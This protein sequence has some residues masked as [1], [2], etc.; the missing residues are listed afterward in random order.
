MPK[1]TKIIMGM[2]ITVEIIDKVASSVFV[3]VFDYFSAIDKRYSTYKKSSE[4]SQING[5]L[6]QLKWSTEMKT[7]FDLCEQT[8]QQTNGYFDIYH[9]DRL[10]PSG[11]VK[12]WSIQNAA[13]L[14][15]EIGVENFYIEAG[16]DI[17]AHG[18][19]ASDE[20]WRVGIRNPFNINEI[21]KTLVISGEGVATSGTYIRGQHI[22]NPHSPNSDINE[23][24]SLTVVGPN[25]YEA[26][27]FATAAFAMG[28]KG[29]GFIES[30]GGLE[31]YMVDDA[32]IATYTSGFKRYQAD[33]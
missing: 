4:I 18:K 17:Q 30:T 9:N 23:V 24:K 29:I 2:P 20:P 22:Y 27:R 32:Q 16:G 15:L 3:D 1:Q 7:V 25:I 33:V 8:K 19:N 5:G 12:G 28:K 11:L 31:G 26:D 10:D 13:Q 6:P 14:L 21:I